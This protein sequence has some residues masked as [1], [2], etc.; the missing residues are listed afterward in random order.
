[1]QPSE[2]QATLTRAHYVIALEGTNNLLFYLATTAEIEDKQKIFPP[3]LCASLGFQPEIRT[4]Y[5]YRS[6]YAGIYN[7]LYQFCV[8][9]LC[10]DI[11]GFFRSL[12]LERGYKVGKGAFFQRFDEVLSELAL[13]GYDF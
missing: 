3:T 5:D 9:S 11:E 10:S 12:F 6:R 7:R 13:N 8:I 4:M 1:M 2:F